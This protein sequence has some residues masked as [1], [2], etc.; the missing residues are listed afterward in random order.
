M[1]SYMYCPNCGKMLPE[2]VDG[3]NL[4]YVCDCGFLKKAE[5]QISC[6]SNGTV[7]VKNERKR[8]IYY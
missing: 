8:D 4:F 3:L 6:N 5:L 7:N 1:N 2:R